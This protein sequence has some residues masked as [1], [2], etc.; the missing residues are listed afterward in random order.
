MLAFEVPRPRDL[1]SWVRA[2]FERVGLEA[3]GEAARA[4]VE[5]V[6]DDATALATEVEKLAAWA[7]GETDR[8]AGGR[9]P[10]R[11]RPGGLCL[12]DHGRLGRP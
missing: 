10:G 4:L 5:I 3:D 2:Q 12:G 9:A 11:T 8:A 7:G 1:P 6:G